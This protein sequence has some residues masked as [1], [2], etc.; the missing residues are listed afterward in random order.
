MSVRYDL[1]VVLARHSG[2]GGGGLSGKI[3]IFYTNW[4]IYRVAQNIIYLMHTKSKT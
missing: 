3:G 4:H 1:A 2:D